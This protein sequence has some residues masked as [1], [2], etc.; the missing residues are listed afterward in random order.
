[1]IEL[2]TGSDR[3]LV[4]VAA[5]ADAEHR[6]LGELLRDAH[7]ARAHDAAL[8]VVD[9]GRTEAHGLR[10][11]HG[12]VAHA[13]LRGLVLEPVVLEP[14]LPGL[15]ADRAVH[16]VIQEQELLHGSACPDHVLARLALDHQAVGGGHL[17]GGLELR[18]LLADVLTLLG[19][20][21]EHLEHHRRSPGGRQHFH[22]AHAA[23]RRDAEAGVP[24]VVWNIHT[25]A[26][27]RADDG[28]ARLERD[29]AVVQ[30]E[31]RHSAP[32]RSHSPP[33]MFSEP[34]QGT[35]SAII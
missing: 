31:T 10:L 8:R 19:V 35:T 17:T 1:M 30:L 4:Q 20:P 3:D 2:A 16:R 18:L 29:L 7:T 12:L 13:L 24:A 27:G 22:Q 34:K 33:I 5:L 21:S 15:I 25:H 6:I 26:V 32:Q 23:V 28:V 11:V 9:D 14:A